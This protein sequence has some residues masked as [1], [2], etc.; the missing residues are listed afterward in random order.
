MAFDPNHILV[1][2]CIVTRGEQFLLTQRSL[3]EEKFPGYWTVPGGTVDE[4]DYTGITPNDAGLWYELIEAMCA[5]EVE[6]EAGV[7][8]KEIGYLISLAYKKRAGRAVCMSMHAQYASG[9]IAPGDETTDAR[10]VTLTEAE[11]MPLIEG[12][13]A[14]LYMLNDIRHGRAVRAWSEYVAQETKKKRKE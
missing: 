10:W 13:L 9:T 1:A 11:A 5:R 3:T 14:E 2:T 12:I 4:E 7:R 8:I 6:E